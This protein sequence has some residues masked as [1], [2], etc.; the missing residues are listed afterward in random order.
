MLRDAPPLAAVMIVGGGILWIV[1]GAFRG[2]AYVRDRR[3]A[4]AGPSPIRQESTF[5]TWLAAEIAGAAIG[6]AGLAWYVLAG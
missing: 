6:I 4:G 5:R 2:L 3:A 1:A